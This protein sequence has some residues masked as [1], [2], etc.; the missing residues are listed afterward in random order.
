VAFSLQQTAEVITT[1]ELHQFLH[2]A[3]PVLEKCNRALLRGGL[4]R[5]VDHSRFFARFRA[6]SRVFAL[7]LFQLDRP[8]Q[9][10]EPPWNES[11]PFTRFAR[12]G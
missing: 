5:L 4:P 3:Q 1:A 8:I 2:T 12:S 11:D 10:R 7:K 9:Q 6:F